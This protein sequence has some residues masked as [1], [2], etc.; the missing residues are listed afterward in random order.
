MIFGGANTNNK[1]GTILAWL[2]PEKEP[3]RHFIADLLQNS[4]ELDKWNVPILLLFKTEKDKDLFLKKNAGE[5]PIKTKTDVTNG[6]SLEDFLKIMN[7]NSF[8]DL[9][10]VTFINTSGE[11]VYFSHGY[12]IGIGEEILRNLHQ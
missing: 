11:I 3:S 8:Q 4:K 10:L 7:K 5:L 1:I 6:N 12:K 9:P 2:E